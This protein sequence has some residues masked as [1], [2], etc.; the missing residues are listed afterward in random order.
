MRLIHQNPIVATDVKLGFNLHP[1][2]EVID[3]EAKIV[4]R[5]SG[6]STA[7][8]D[9]DA[10]EVAMIISQLNSKKQAAVD[11][12]DFDLAKQIKAG[13]DFFLS[14]FNSIQKLQYVMN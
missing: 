11:A 5:G 1:L 4:L 6:S 2:I 3:Q 14:K 8:A 13:Y 7:P 12:E 10:G 9:S